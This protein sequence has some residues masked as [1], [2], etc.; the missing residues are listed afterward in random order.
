MRRHSHSV[1]RRRRPGRGARSPTPP[2]TAH[3]CP[4]ERAPSPAKGTA[5]RLSGRGDPPPPFFLT[6]QPPPP[7]RRMSVPRPQSLRG[8]APS[9]LSFHRRHPS[10]KPPAKLGQACCR[11]PGGKAFLAPTSLDA[12]GVHPLW[13]G[14]R[15]SRLLGS[16][17]RE[18][19]PPSLPPLSHASLG[20]GVNRRCC[21]GGGGITPRWGGG[22]RANP[23]HPRHGG[24][25][26]RDT[27]TRFAACPVS[28]VGEGR[29]RDRL[30]EPLAV[31]T[32]LYRLPLC[33]PAACSG[34]QA[35][36]ARSGAAAAVPVAP[37]CAPAA[38]VPR[39]PQRLQRAS[40][41]AQCP[42]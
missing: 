24:C 25:D 18:P 22:V 30:P 3:R 16:A 20:R 23:T 41:A 34:R 42:A 6:P 37:G 10:W 9:E 35:A 12:R 8:R 27:H 4:R 33:P 15:R 13:P 36:A 26:R 14:T 39:S 21:V 7:P 1:P 2:R 17:P 29:R 19:P 31:C 5:P 40:S 11:R 32:V 28:V 38:A